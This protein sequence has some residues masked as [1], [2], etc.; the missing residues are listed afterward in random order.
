M[1]RSLIS[2][3]LVILCAYIL[4]Y[5]YETIQALSSLLQLQSTEAFLN[6]GLVS[7]RRSISSLCPTKNSQLSL[8]LRKVCT[9]HELPLD[10]I[11]RFDLQTSTY[12]VHPFKSTMLRMKTVAQDGD[13][14]GGECLDFSPSSSHPQCSS[15]QGDFGRWLSL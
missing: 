13:V 7:A 12:R 5:P 15:I 11:M 14:V 1:R 2:M 3:A 9:L 10:L 6:C 4:C 8:Q